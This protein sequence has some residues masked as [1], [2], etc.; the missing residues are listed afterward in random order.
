MEEYTIQVNK[1]EELQ[2]T[3]DIHALNAI[4]Q[5]AKETIVSG[6]EVILERL[7][8]NGQPFQ[9]DKITTLEDLNIYKK[10]VYKYL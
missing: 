8:P 1:V 3:N 9:F 2:A 6:L 7:Q 4:F 5:K 10:Q